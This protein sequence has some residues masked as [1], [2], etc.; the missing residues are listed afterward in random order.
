M[1]KRSVLVPLDASGLAGFGVCGEFWAL[2]I[3]ATT[4]AKLTKRTAFKA[5]VVKFLIG[6]I[7][8]LLAFD[9]AG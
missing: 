5:F 2:H 1:I 4:N 8:F 3:G 6:L 7:L 9:T